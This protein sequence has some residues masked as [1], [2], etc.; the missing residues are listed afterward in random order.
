MQLLLSWTYRTYWQ[1][2]YPTTYFYTPRLFAHCD[3]CDCMYL[4]WSNKMLHIIKHQVT[5]KDFFLY[6]LLDTLIH[7]DYILNLDIFASH[8]KDV[9][10]R[11][12]HFRYY[13]CV[14]FFVCTKNLWNVVHL[15]GIFLSSFYSFISNDVKSGAYLHLHNLRITVKCAKEIS[16]FLT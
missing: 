9:Q 14:I 15:L 5:W 12:W 6:F 10:F 4:S 16:W 7:G 2:F 3:G 1:F 11:W 13:L 8:T